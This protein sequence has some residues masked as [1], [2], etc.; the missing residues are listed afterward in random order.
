[1]ENTVTIAL[2]TRLKR[3]IFSGDAVADLTKRLI[4]KE[5]A[6]LQLQIRYIKFL[7]YGLIITICS[8][9]KMDAEEIVYRFRKCTSS[10]LRDVFPEL[11]SMP[12][13]WNRN[14]LLEKGVLDENKQKDID[15]FYFSLKAR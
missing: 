12:S 1:M 15:E 13:V 3:R 11:K 9:E 2:A 5:A 8:H 14:F 6:D 10:V 7:D 4:E